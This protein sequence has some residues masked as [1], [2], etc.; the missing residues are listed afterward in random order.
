MEIADDQRVGAIAQEEALVDSALDEMEQRLLEAD[1]RE[2]AA[3]ALTLARAGRKG[4]GASLA[5]LRS[6]LLREHENDLAKAV[7]VAME[8]L[9]LRPGRKL[10]RADSGYRWTD[11][12]TGE[13]IFV[14][15]P[16][17]AHWHAL[18]RWGPALRPRIDAVGLFFGSDTA[19]SE[20]MDAVRDGRVVLVT[21]ES[22]NPARPH[23]A[24]RMCKAGFA[25]DAGLQTMT[26]WSELRSLGWMTDG[27]ERLLAFEPLQGEPQEL[28]S[29]PSCG[30]ESLLSLMNTIANIARPQR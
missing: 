24:L 28:P 30:V 1:P 8:L 27:N 10:E 3:L 5:R 17:A 15:D 11:D 25:R 26:R 4:S 6:R 23:S 22:M 18:H 21:F 12:A 19:E 2:S 29:R 16:L 7:L 20:A 9:P 14:D 13:E